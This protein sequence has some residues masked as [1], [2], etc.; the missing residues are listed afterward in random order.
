MPQFPG[1]PAASLWANTPFPLC[2]L[3]SWERGAAARSLHLGLAG[4][5][6]RGTP[7]C[8]RLC[9]SSA[10]SHSSPLTGRKLKS[11]LTQCVFPTCIY[12]LFKNG[13]PPKMLPQPIRTEV[14]PETREAGQGWQGSS[15]RWS[16]GARWPS[17]KALERLGRS[18]PLDSAHCDPGRLL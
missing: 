10:S 12:L 2:L 4:G 13:A 7:A 6:G 1:K 16:T 11:L 9:A 15:Q 14:K 5:G 18:F 3:S 8:V 17:G